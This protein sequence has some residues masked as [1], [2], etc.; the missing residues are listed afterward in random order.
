MGE[1]RGISPDRLVTPPCEELLC[2]TCRKLVRSPVTCPVC[3][4]VYCSG[5][6]PKQRCPAC[7]GAKLETLKGLALR[8]YE[9]VQVKCRCGKVVTI[10]ELDRH[11]SQCQAQDWQ[12]RA[13]ELASENEALRKENKA[14][15]EELAV[16]KAPLSKPAEAP[17]KRSDP[18]A[19]PK[20]AEERKALAEPRPAPKQPLDRAPAERPKQPAER[21]LPAAR[22][23]PPE[24][25][26]PSKQPLLS[27]AD[28]PK[29]PVFAEK[30]RPA[31]LPKPP[32]PQAPPE[33]PEAMNQAATTIQRAFRMKKARELRAAL[34]EKRAERMQQT[35][36]KRKR[37]EAQAA[38]KGVQQV[39]QNL[40]IPKGPAKGK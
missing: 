39:V 11:E 7:Q 35:A 31:E 26:L 29:Q 15:R 4:T 19:R 20:P 9:G 38:F 12:Q 25:P 22:Q 27:P 3:V 34:Q 28:R 5:C 14:L 18:P 21:P 30:P 16:L 13:K 17:R 24:H 36:F 37:N 33:R 32:T 23:N 2:S 10:G 6:L 40:N 8:M 1:K